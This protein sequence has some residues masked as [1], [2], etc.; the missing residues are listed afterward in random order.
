MENKK[1]PVKRG[2]E[3]TLTI[4]DLAYGGNG[5]AR[6]ENFTIFVAEGIPGDEVTAVITLVKKNFAEAQIKEVI[7]ESQD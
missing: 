1:V 2:D 7:K 5:V 3:V 6:Y 4:T